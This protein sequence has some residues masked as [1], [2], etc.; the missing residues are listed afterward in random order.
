MQRSFSSSLANQTKTVWRQAPGVAVQQF[1]WGQRNLRMLSG[2]SVKYAHLVPSPTKGA[3]LGDRTHASS[4][5]SIHHGNGNSLYRNPGD[6]EG[7]LWAGECSILIITLITIMM[8]KIIII[9]S[10][11]NKISNNKNIIV[12]SSLD[13]WGSCTWSKHNTLLSGHN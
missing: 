12:L 4:D 9:T 7:S 6:H 5:C 10:Q 3:R 8:I 1:L 11:N 2:K 13:P